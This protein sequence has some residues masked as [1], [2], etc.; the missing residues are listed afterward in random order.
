M[1]LVQWTVFPL[2][3]FL[4]LFIGCS[5]RQSEVIVAEIG[6][7][8]IS[9]NEYERFFTRNASG[10]ESGKSSTQEEREHFLD[11]LT[12]YKLKLLDANAQN[13][14]NDP[15]I[16][17]ELQDYR[18]SLA[19]TYLIDKEITEPGVSVTYDR[20]HEDIRAQQI[21]ISMK[22]SA[23]PAE[24]LAAWTKAMDIVKRARSGDN[25]DSLALAYSTDPAVRTNHGDTYYFTGGQ[26]TT[27]FENAAYALKKGEIAESP[28][29][30]QMGYHIIKI[31]DRVPSRG[32]MK[33]SHI[34]A[35]FK[36]SDKDSINVASALD[37]IHAMQD[38]LKRGW[39]FAKLATKFSEDPG[40]APTGGDL[41]W[42]ER[43]RW[44]QPFDEACFKLAPGQVSDIVKTPFGYHFIRCDSSK[45]VPPLSEIHEELKKRFQ[46]TRYNEEYAGYILNLKRVYRYSFNNVVFDSVM[47][48]IDSLKS[49]GD[50]AWA[51]GIP[52][53]VRTQTLLSING[54]SHSLDTVLSILNRRSE[55]RNTLLRR[56]DLLSRL[57]RIGETLLLGE[58]AI[59]L[60]KRDPGFD[61]LLREYE[62]GVVLFRAEQLSVWN[63][64]TVSDSALRSCSD[65]NRGKFMFPER[66]AFSEIHVSTDTL[67]ILLYD[68]L[69]SG[70]NFATLAAQYNE[71]Q[72]LRN[73]RGVHGLR[74]VNSD[75]LSTVAAKLKVG[76]IS[77]PTEVQTG[78]F[79]ILKLTKRE[80]PREKT[81]EEA[82]AEVSNQY[83]EFLSK[84]IEQQWIDRLRQQY[85]VKQYK[86]RLQAAFGSQQ[87]SH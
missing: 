80:Q 8:K 58:K 67:A 38:S 19:S 69:S 18:S 65:Q 73:K 59:G 7:T 47:S 4:L 16:Q 40:S 51:N 43:R 85:L 53:D 34:M 57:E 79:S 77:E 31:L 10:M 87:A 11:L 23:S 12:N 62:D 44:V 37:R 49:I 76:E 20:R 75:E 15:E 70:A 24:T 48:H 6:P 82:G 27:A 35:R 74:A 45:P 64:V 5:P 54:K 41:G 81:Y 72:D 32:S 3:A 13:L 2:Y 86:E 78:G 61:M 66:V 33:V 83:Q 42:F 17:Q 52:K 30:S 39:D 36:V 21:L 56:A 50:S 63:K 28:V 14:Q 68:S 60:E 55:Y 25:F 1:K 46:Q 26:M 22:S 9:L 71:S 29:R 84:Q